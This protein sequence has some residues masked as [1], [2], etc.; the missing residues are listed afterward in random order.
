M[1]KALEAREEE[2]AQQFNPQEVGNILWADALAARWGGGRCEMGRRPSEPLRGLLERRV[3]DI[4]LQ[5]VPV[6]LSTQ[7]EQYG[8][9]RDAFYQENNKRPSKPHS[10]CAL[11]CATLAS[12][13]AMMRRS[14]H[15]P[16]PYSLEARDP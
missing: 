1:P 13:A 11:G 6:V 12:T 14:T 8:A 16:T 7:I 2:V 9:P 10:S 4:D 15:A 3:T 5:S